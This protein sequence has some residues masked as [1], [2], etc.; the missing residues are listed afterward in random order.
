MRGALPFRRVQVM[1]L[2]ED[3]PEK[4]EQATLEIRDFVQRAGREGGRAIVIPYRV[5]GF[6]PYAEALKGL[7]YVSDGHG[8]VPHPQVT[9]WVKRQ[10]EV[11]R[12]EGF[13]EKQR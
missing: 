6:G 10:A 2:R 8:L 13:A 5:Q 3:W 12:K 11:M 4:R 9:A 1:S 7:D